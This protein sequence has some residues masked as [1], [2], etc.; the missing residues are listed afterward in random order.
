M[1]HFVRTMASA[2]QRTM[3][4]RKN[5]LYFQ[6]EVPKNAFYITDGVVKAYTIN[7]DG[8]EAIVSLHSKGEILPSTWLTRQSSTSLLYYQAMSDVRGIE[9]KRSTIEDITEANTQC[10]HGLLHSISITN[11]HSLMRGVALAQPRAFEK[12]CLTFLYLVE[13]KGRKRDDNMWYIDLK[14]SQTDIAQMIG[15]TRENTAKNIKI[16]REK[17]ILIYATSH[18]SV[19][20]KKIKSMLS[21]DQFRNVTLH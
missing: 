11:A 9:I 16:L 21:E 6:G 7:D 14:L 12:L 2:G 5:M 10:M 18:Y 15:Q 19:S 13:I 20:R 17:N 4:H 1:D 8:T 3:K